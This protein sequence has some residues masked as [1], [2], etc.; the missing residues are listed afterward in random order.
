MPF[1]VPGFSVAANAWLTTDEDNDG[2]TAWPEWLAGTDP[3]N[4]DTNGNG[5]LD[6]IEESG[7]VSALNP[8]DCPCAETE[9]H[10]VQWMRAQTAT[11]WSNPDSP[12]KSV[13]LRV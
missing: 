3:Y 4:P 5:P 11:I 7:T 12:A 2:L 9:V 8:D 1:V 10:L 6:G 13:G